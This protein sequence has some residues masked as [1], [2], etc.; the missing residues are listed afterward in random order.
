MSA[1]EI[2]LGPEWIRLPT[3]APAQVQP[4]PPV[5]PLGP[6]LLPAEALVMLS[7]PEE[8]EAALPTAVL[9]RRTGF[10]AL[11]RPGGHVGPYA[12]EGL[13]SQAPGATFYTGRSMDGTRL[14]LQ[15]I[16]LRAVSSKAER[17]ERLYVERRLAALTRNDPAVVLAHGGAE[18]ADG[19]RALFWAL[20][21]PKS[22]LALKQDRRLD[23]EAVLKTGLGLAQRLV[24]RH[25][26]GKSDPLL[27]EATVH[28][29]PIEASTVLGLPIAAPQVWL[30]SG[31]APRR[32][33]AEEA[34]SNTTVPSGDVYRL[35]Q[36]LAMLAAPL[37]TLPPMLTVLLGQ[38]ADPNPEARGSAANAL[39]GLQ[40]LLDAVAA[41]VL[42]IRFA[43]SQT[44]ATDGYD[45]DRTLHVGSDSPGEISLVLEAEAPAT[46]FEAPRP[47]V[48]P[49]FTAEAAA[50][51]LWSVSRP[52]HAPAPSRLR[53]A[54]RA[55][56]VFSERIAA[57]R[58]LEVPAATPGPRS[59]AAPISPRPPTSAPTAVAA[60]W[61]AE[62]APVRRVEW[63]E[64]AAAPPARELRSW[65]LLGMG[66]A[67][68]VGIALGVWSTRCFGSEIPSASGSNVALLR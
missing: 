48:D 24:A 27:S 15:L 1:R 45:P 66:L 25:A 34:I 33:A 51:A 41:P 47:T 59:Q 29:D 17:V 44:L 28:G 49:N 16:R 13:L 35:G 46:H 11:V 42:A 53:S 39:A 38:L 57:P 40:S 22:A 63:P 32:L 3:P 7:D 6:E 36:T 23:L 58:I 14:L 60:R 21:L 2:E 67:L 10:T 30:S 12:I 19:Q 62:K 52:V 18:E 50:L 56:A 54:V 8:E 20:P 37:P 68:I 65:M 26:D 61:V 55:E 31:M 64:P 5:I 9:D 4:L 43:G